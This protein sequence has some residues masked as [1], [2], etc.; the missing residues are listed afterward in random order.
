MNEIIK[1]NLSVSLRLFS[2]HFT[3]HLLWTSV[4]SCCWVLCRTS[5]DPD[6]AWQ[7][8]ECDL[9]HT[10]KL[11]VSSSCNCVKGS[12]PWLQPTL[13]RRENSDLSLTCLSTSWYFFKGRTILAVPVT[14][15]CW[16]PRMQCWPVMSYSR[17][18]LW[19][20]KIII[21]QLSVCKLVALLSIFTFCILLVSAT[22]QRNDV[23]KH[24]DLNK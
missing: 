5:V 11:F 10:W 23:L 6:Q 22:S 18:W 16:H 3:S 14:W 1:H 24:N 19:N 2:W 12:N 7:S 13:W 15:E 8:V 4:A 21:F 9:W 20:I 17:N